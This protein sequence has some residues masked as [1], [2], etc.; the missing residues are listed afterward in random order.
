M[1]LR[2]PVEVINSAGRLKLPADP[3]PDMAAIAAIAQT[4]IRHHPTLA[5][6]TWKSSIRQI[7]EAL[8]NIE[9]IYDK[10]ENP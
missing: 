6:S 9:D 1:K 4:C 8:E 2:D 3:G 5:L 10:A 7:R